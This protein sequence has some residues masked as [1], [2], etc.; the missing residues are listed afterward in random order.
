MPKKSVFRG[1]FDKQPGKLAQALLKCAS[2][3]IYQIF[4]NVS[5]INMQNLGTAC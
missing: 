3:H 4:K 5:L 2:H 1:P